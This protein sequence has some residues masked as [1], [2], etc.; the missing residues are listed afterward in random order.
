[1][2]LKK[3]EAALAF[4]KVAHA[5]KL[6][7]PSA[8]LE[9]LLRKNF[10]LSAEFLLAEYYPHT[11]MD[12]EV[13]IKNVAREVQRQQGY[14]IFLTKKKETGDKFEQRKPVLYWAQTVDDVLMQLKI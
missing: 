1:M 2:P 7:F 13:I 5:E 4:L 12:T 10:F 14:M 9:I 11:T 6:K 8:C 3:D